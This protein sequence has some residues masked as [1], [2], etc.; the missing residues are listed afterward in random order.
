MRKLRHRA[1]DALPSGWGQ[2]VMALCGKDTGRWKALLAQ[3]DSIGSGAIIPQLPLKTMAS[4][5]L[6]FSLVNSF[7]KPPL[8]LP[9]QAPR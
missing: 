9:V 4:L 6:V 1:T 3:Q 8:H 7:W 5:Q 2:G